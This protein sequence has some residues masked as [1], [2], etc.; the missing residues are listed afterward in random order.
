MKLFSSIC[1]ALF[2]FALSGQVQMENLMND[3]K[4]YNEAYINQDHVTFTQYTI[5]S[6]VE[7][8]GGEEIMS[9]VNKES[10]K[11]FASSGITIFSLTP[12]DPEDVKSVNGEENFAIVPQEM[13]LK[14]ANKKFKKIAYF[15]ARSNNYGK[16]WTFLDLEPYD[17]KSIKEF[18]PL[19]PDDMEIPK[20][21]D[22]LSEVK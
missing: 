11:T 12:Q 10:F 19:F 8:G 13:V 18:I 20:V 4:K 21:N 3:I 14:V 2:S 16:S 7:K 5:P 22:A 6:V 9:D 1:L 17:E 15:L